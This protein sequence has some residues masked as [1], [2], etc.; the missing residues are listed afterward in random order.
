[1]VG[2]EEVEGLLEEVAQVPLP[3]ERDGG[4]VVVTGAVEERALDVFRL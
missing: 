3:P 1:V 4:A 2:V